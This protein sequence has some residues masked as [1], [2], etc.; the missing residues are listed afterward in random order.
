VLFETA[1]YARHACCLAEAALAASQHESW[2]FD[3][4]AEIETWFDRVEPALTVDG[5]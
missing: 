3:S 2:G 4:L 5:G 1:E